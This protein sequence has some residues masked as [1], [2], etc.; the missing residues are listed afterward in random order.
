MAKV[1]WN[2]LAPTSH[3][4]KTSRKSPD[5]VAQSV[6]LSR[7]Y[8]AV[9]AASPRSCKYACSLRQTGRLVPDP[10]AALGDPG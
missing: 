10:R 1:E 7:D 3:T 4:A 9:V 2:V 8:H 6:Q 5:P